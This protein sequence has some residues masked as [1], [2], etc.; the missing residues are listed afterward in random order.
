MDSSSFGRAL[1]FT[2]VA[3]W[4]T[5]AL[6]SAGDG[7][8][9]SKDRAAKYLDERGKAW[10]EFKSAERGERANKSTCVSCHTLVPYALARP[11]LRRLSGTM[12]PTVYE[13]RLLDQTR[14]RVEHWQQLDSKEFDLLYSFSEPKKKEA[15][16]TEAVL[17]CLIL[18]FD[19]Q[20]EGRDRPSAV[21]TKAFAHLWQTQAA[22]GDKAGSW[23]WLDF[24]LQPW[25]TK[26]ARY[27][28]ATLA[29]IAVGTAPGYCTAGK[30]AEIDK[31]VKLLKSYLRAHLPD[32]NL[33]NRIWMLW[34]ASK[35][36]GLLSQTEQQPIV[37]ALLEK[38][39]ADGGWD[40]SSLVKKPRAG[41]GVNAIDSDA[42][43]TGLIVHVLQTAGI[44]KHDSGLAR[45]LAWLQA[46]QADSGA[47]RSNSVNKER[48]PNTHVGK[49]MSDAATAF[50]VL[51]LSH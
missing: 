21:T 22:D 14:K 27:F 29:A 47:W 8:T 16:G 2:A 34:A 9:W 1:P 5:A 15:R 3:F 6:A 12:Q 39:H 43:A 31:R 17:N 35:L 44:P 49:F 18:A 19:D 28:G 25:E 23:D 32:Q 42:Y 26:E 4:L 36:D 46:H 11:A 30:D 20:Y 40:L 33:N 13:T 41:A 38:Q 51:A 45:G 24:G 10:F 50:A 48:D 7:G 37:Q